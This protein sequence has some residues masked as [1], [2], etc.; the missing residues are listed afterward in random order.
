MRTE[1]FLQSWR[2]VPPPFDYLPLD[3]EARFTRALAS[4]W[5]AEEC[6]QLLAQVGAARTLFEAGRGEWLCWAEGARQ[7]V[8][9][10][11][12]R[13]QVRRAAVA[14]ARGGKRAADPVAGVWPSGLQEV[15][16][17][18]LQV[19]G[20]EL[21]APLESVRPA[22]SNVRVLAVLA[23]RRL[24]LQAAAIFCGDP[25]AQSARLADD[26]PCGVMPHRLRFAFLV[27]LFAVEAA[28]LAEFYA[29]QGRATNREL[30]DA[31]ATAGRLLEFAHVALTYSGAEGTA[32]NF[33]VL[34]REFFNGK[35]PLLAGKQG[36]AD[37]T[38]ARV[39]SAL[40]DVLRAAPGALDKTAAR[41]AIADAAGV[42][43]SRVSEVLRSRPESWPDVLREG[44]EALLTDWK[45]RPRR[46]PHT[47]ARR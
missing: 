3:F 34:W 18:V 39:F 43:E 4:S 11:W 1:K 27:M 46:S 31:L 38:R 15:F 26:P 35:V 23:V 13:D 2:F 33:D 25:A 12:L 9:P 37:E 28:R 24:T 5:L 40:A 20:V 8:S 29:A 47:R 22:S 17:D 10:D 30:F 14:K 36:Q 45:A 7:P 16:E 32:A 21:P 19:V 6:P 41:A 42:S 44:W